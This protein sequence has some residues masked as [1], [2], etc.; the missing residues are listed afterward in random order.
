MN[1]SISTFLSSD[2]YAVLGA[3]SNREKFGNRVF[4]AI[5][6][7]GR[8]A[9]PIN[10]TATSVEGHAAFVSIVELPEVPDSISIITP[11]KVTREL[12]ATAITAGVKNIWMQPGAQDEVASQSARAAGLNV[13]DDGSC[14]LVFLEQQAQG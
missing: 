12:V 8:L 1:D 2:A 5:L 3:S 6:G 7:S 9:Y 13:I 11:P 10:P 14:I 4:R